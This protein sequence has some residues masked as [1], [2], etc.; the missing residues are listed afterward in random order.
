MNQLKDRDRK[1]EFKKIDNYKNS[2]QYSIVT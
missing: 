2:F 1:N